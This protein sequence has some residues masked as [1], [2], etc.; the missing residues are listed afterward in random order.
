[1]VKPLPE[2]ATTPRAPTISDVASEAQV[3]KSTVSRY[4]NG[5]TVAR[6]AEIEAAIKKLGFQPSRTARS[7]VSGTTHLVGVVVPDIT[8]PYFSSVVK[9]IESVGRDNGYH[10]ML[11]NTDESADL[12]EVVIHELLERSVD[13]LIMAPAK[14]EP[15]LPPEL[16]DLRVP[17]VFVD[18][19]L[20]VG[21]FDAVQVNNAGGMRQ[22]V[23]HVAELGHE[24]I[25]LISGPLDTS[26]GRQRYEGFVEGMEAR[27]LELVEEYVALGD[28]REAGGLQAA[29]RLAGMRPT[30][31]AIV[32]A[33]NLM[34][35]GALKA[36]HSLGITLPDDMSFVGFDDLELAELISPPLTVVSRPMEQQG[37]LAMKL[38]LDR[39][40]KRPTRPAQSL[41]LDTTLIPRGSTGPPA[42]APRGASS[43]RRR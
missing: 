36:F 35:M 17:V 11:C 27:G 33:N 24:R 42:P 26:P 34:S 18:R 37:V 40:E 25:A 39:V 12:E 7:L 10:V 6:G 41:V 29:L 21:E 8:N 15:A 3:S 30:P 5:R 22:A 32:S 20:G 14:E 1:L 4:I 23:E 19:I 16:A 31:T 2:I 43:E 13:G 9:G 38:L 28:F